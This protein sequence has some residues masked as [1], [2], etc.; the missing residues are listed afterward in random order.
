MLYWGIVYLTKDEFDMPIYEYH[1]DHCQQDFEKLVS[2]SEANREP[3]C[4]I[5]QSQQ[6]RK[7]ISKVA[8]FNQGS[9]GSAVYSGSCGSS[10]GFS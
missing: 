7:K 1:C 2:F 6:T 5:C 8:G 9:A 4:P 10:G 3:V